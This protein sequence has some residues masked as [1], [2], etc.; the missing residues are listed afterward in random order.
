MRESMLVLVHHSKP[1]T[2]AWFSVMIFEMEVIL[3]PIYDSITINVKI[4]KN[5][6]IFSA[7][8]QKYIPENQA[9]RISATSEQN[10]SSIKINLLFANCTAL[11]FK[12]NSRNRLSFFQMCVPA[13]MLTTHTF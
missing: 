7:T 1:R 6:A 9:T 3:D 4:P 10:V 5:H 13:V 12:H 2:L 8:R 11:A